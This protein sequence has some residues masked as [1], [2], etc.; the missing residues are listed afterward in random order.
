[1]VGSPTCLCVTASASNEA[2]QELN[3]M[4]EVLVNASVALSSAAAFSGRYKS[5]TVVRFP[6][7]AKGLAENQAGAKVKRPWQS[8]QKSVAFAVFGL[9][10]IIL[11]VS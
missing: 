2:E 4:S 8:R 3:W 6:D 10:R 11:G 9:F 1:M 7:Q 5:D